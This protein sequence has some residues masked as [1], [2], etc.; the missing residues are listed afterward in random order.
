MLA[1][2]LLICRRNKSDPAH[3]HGELNAEPAAA[4]FTPEG[5]CMTA[6]GALVWVPVS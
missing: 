3:L 5:G 2:D 1:L 6:E 4:R